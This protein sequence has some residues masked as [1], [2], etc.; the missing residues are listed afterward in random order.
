MKKLL[1]GLRWKRRGVKLPSGSQVDSHTRIGYGTRINGS[2]LIKGKARCT[3]GRYCALGSD[4]KIIT[5][6]HLM[7]YAN[8]QCNLQRKIGAVELDVAKGEV[9]I[10]HNVWIGDNAMILSGVKIGNGAVIG[11]GAVVTRDIPDFAVAAGVPAKVLRLRFSPEVC[12]QLNA[13]HWW[14]WAP[15]R[16]ARN[17]DLFNVDLA[18]IPPG[19]SL[20]SFVKS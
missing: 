18:Q 1:E 6:N 15:E 12:E 11:A 2:I 5:S 13:L 17:A 3:I 7:N 20:E 9:V 16:I 4:V 8:L 19:T 10:G 14:D